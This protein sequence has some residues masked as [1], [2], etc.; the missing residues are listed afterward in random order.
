MK[1]PRG[2]GKNYF[3]LNAITATVSQVT[4]KAQKSRVVFCHL[5]YFEDDTLEN[6]SEEDELTT[7][8]LTQP[9]QKS[10]HCNSFFY[11]LTCRILKLFYIPM[12][13][14]NYHKTVSKTLSPP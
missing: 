1:L 10:C 12:F 9:S 2:F 13:F 8:L 4:L 14:E 6:E 3:S 7:T 11:T 5:N